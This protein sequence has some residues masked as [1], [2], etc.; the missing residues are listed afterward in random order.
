MCECEDEK[1]A[2]NSAYC[3]SRLIIKL[4]IQ[5]GVLAFEPTEDSSSFVNTYLIR[6]R[7]PIHFHFQQYQKLIKKF[8]CAHALYILNNSTLPVGLSSHS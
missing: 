1:V 4:A 7:N 5:A 2:K 8:F 3:D 6:I